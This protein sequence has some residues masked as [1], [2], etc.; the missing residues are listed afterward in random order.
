MVLSHE[1][2]VQILCFIVSFVFF[3]YTTNA[4]DHVYV[5]ATIYVMN[6]ISM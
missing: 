4:M 2:Y 6:Y 1:L 5:Y 3:V